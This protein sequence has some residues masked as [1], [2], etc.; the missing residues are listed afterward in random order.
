MLRWEAENTCTNFSLGLS[1][2]CR[3]GKEFDGLV[4]SA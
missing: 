3:P 2:P 1:W 4:Y